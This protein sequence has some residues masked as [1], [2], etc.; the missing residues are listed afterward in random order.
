MDTAPLPITYSARVQDT[1]AM[2]GRGAFEPNRSALSKFYQTISQ[3]DIFKKF[4]S[5]VDVEKRYDGLSTGWQSHYFAAFNY[6]LRTTA[7]GKQLAARVGFDPFGSSAEVWK[8]TVDAVFVDEQ[9]L[10][11][12]KLSLDRKMQSSAPHLAS[13]VKLILNKLFVGKTD[14]IGYDF[15]CGLHIDLPFIASDLSQIRVDKPLNKYNHPVSITKGIGVDLHPANEEWVRVCTALFARNA[16]EAAKVDAEFSQLVK[17]RESQPAAY[18]TI[19]ASILDFEPAE[20]SDFLLTKRMRYQ[21][22]A[23]DQENIKKSIF[24]AL[25]DGG[26]W[27]TVAE[28]EYIPYYTDRGLKEDNIWVYQKKGD[29]LVRLTEKPVIGIERSS[30]KISSFDQNFFR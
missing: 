23:D 28:E 15:G 30:G 2:K 13:P 11:E 26:Y 18:P 16:V 29:Q 27:I 5:V 6:A 4:A 10:N 7:Q 22:N 8:S 19:R 24:R 9:I 3:P 25:K 20:Q 21:Y 12:F 1:L 17:L 14:L